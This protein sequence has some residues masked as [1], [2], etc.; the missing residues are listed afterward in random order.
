[1]RVTDDQLEA[2]KVKLMERASVPGNWRSRLRKVLIAS[3]RPPLKQ[4]RALLIEG[5]RITTP[6]AEID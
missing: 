4:L 1:M 2:M 5:E 6:L 3:A